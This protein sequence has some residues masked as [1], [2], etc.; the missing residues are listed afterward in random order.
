MFFNGS[1]SKLS[2]E[3]TRGKSWIGPLDFG[4]SVR[5]YPNCLWTSFCGSHAT[6]DVR[7][8][9]SFLGLG[10]SIWKVEIVINYLSHKNDF[11]NKCS[12]IFRMVFWG[13]KTCF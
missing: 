10:V 7:Q 13:G 1:T 4:S 6:D 8:I 9:V 5:N 11:K 2:I 3:E 12:T